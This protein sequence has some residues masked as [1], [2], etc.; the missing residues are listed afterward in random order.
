[1]LKSGKLNPN[2]RGGYESACTMCGEAVWVK[3]SR[4]NRK[5]H[6]C[7]KACHYKWMSENQRGENCTAWRGGSTTRECMICGKNF[8]VLRTDDRRGRGIYCSTECASKARTTKKAVK[9]AHCGKEILVAPYRTTA[10]KNFFCGN[11]C[12]STFQKK[13]RTPEETG[14]RKLNL[15]ISA[16]MGYLLKGNKNGCK[17]ESLVNYTLDDLKSH[18][19]S[20]FKDGMT[21]ENIGEWHIDHI[22]P[23]SLFNFSKPEDAEFLECWGINNLQ[24]LWAIENLQKGCKYTQSSTSR[25]AGLILGG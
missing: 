14:M 9:C 18:L 22:K 10:G 1:M 15:R 5:N 6:F 12:K 17:W 2:W 8:T 19:E 21:W 25:L 20:K 13:E 11:N 4:S 23:R 16:L 24:P 3:P 7:S